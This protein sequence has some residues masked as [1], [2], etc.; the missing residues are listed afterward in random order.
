MTHIQP[1]VPLHS[2]IHIHGNIFMEVICPC[3]RVGTICIVQIVHD[4]CTIRPKKL[5]P[6]VLTAKARLHTAHATTLNTLRPRQKGRHLNENAWILLKISLKFFPKVRI[7]NIP[8]LVQIMAWR[9]I[10]DSCYQRKSQTVSILSLQ[11]HGYTCIVYLVWKSRTLN[12]CRF[13]GV[14]YKSTKNDCKYYKNCCFTQ[15]LKDF[16]IWAESETFFVRMRV[17]KLEF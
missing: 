4:A 5:T 17:Q 8:A 1:A 10:W 16:K 2:L 13:T 6:G 11:Q 12:V 3:G 15:M 9:R 7:N 14:L